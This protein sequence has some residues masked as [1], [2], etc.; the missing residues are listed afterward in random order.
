MPAQLDG[1]GRVAPK[2]FQSR[3]QDLVYNVDVGP[4][5]QA[6][7]VAL[8]VLMVLM[9]MLFYTATQFRGLREQDPMDA[10]QL[11]RNLLY[12]K[13]YATQCVRPLSIGYLERKTGR[14]PPI[15][16]GHP[17]LIRPPLYPAVLAVMFK[18]TAPPFK[19]EPKPG[20]F[21]AEQRAVIPFN[22]GMTLLTGLLL[23][24]LARRLF[25]RRVGFLSTTVF[26][27]SDTVWNSSISGS[28]TAL[29]MLLTVGTVY[30]ALAASSVLREKQPPRRAVVLLL[31]ASALTAAA[32]LTRYAM[33]V[34]VPAIALL[35]GVYV[36]GRRGRRWAGL[37]AAVAA[38][39]V[40]PW[41]ARNIMVC[42]APLGL[43]PVMALEGTRLFP[44][45]Q[46]TR[47]LNPEFRFGAVLNALQ[48]K[49]LENVPRL[50]QVNLRTLGDGILICLFI[51]SFLHRFV[52][53]PV[54]ILR[55]PLALAVLLLVGIAGFY[56]D[57]TARLLA[58]FWPLMIPYAM[59]F[60]LVLLT[61]WQLSLQ[62]L[63]SAVVWLVVLLTAL[64][65]IFRILPPREGPPY[66]PYYPPFAVLVS[67]MLE[68]NEVMCSDMP[69]ATAWYGNR[70][71]IQLPVTIDDFYQ[72][73]DFIQ[74]ISGLYFTTLTR[75]KRYVSDLLTG[76][77]KS[78]FPVLEGRIPPDFPLTQG[79]PLSDM[80]QIFLTDRKRW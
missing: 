2:P 8:Y 69:W 52:R 75:D 11:G 30:S 70:T 25:D 29:L 79:F 23:F 42:R 4:G 41:I 63:E 57:V 12:Y 22:L 55:W 44:G 18:L 62:I 21:P 27:L 24:F 56:G 48:I 26:F 46:L 47:L 65:L 34:L 60:F 1:D 5:H 66:P 32:F 73:N 78:W 77:E 20:V 38:T 17:E 15:L 74:R 19:V 16:V 31:L 43:A 40:L 50:Y 7:K 64:P 76:T 59:A 68:P 13:Q 35:I 28:G 80:D 58:V 6:V 49:W 9:V 72:I 53:R 54:Q 51:T 71:S 61:R 45:D 14:R 37:Y 10:A 36:G 3:I 67:N 33:A 39:L